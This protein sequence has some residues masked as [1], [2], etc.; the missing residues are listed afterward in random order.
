M[1]YVDFIAREGLLFAI[2]LSHSDD[3]FMFLDKKNG[4]LQ[5]LYMSFVW[6]SVCYIMVKY[7][8]VKQIFD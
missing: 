7:T 5:T 1:H 4:R 8:T 2:I 3:T 6:A